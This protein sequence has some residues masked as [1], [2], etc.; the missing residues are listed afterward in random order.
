MAGQHGEVG[1]QRP[2]RW[3]VPVRAAPQFDEHVLHNVL[4]G[5][6]VPQD[7]QRAAVHTRCQ[8]VEDLGQSLAVEDADTVY[9]SW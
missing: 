8:L 1:A 4:R 2:D 9:E 3:I 6:A 7:P 5:A